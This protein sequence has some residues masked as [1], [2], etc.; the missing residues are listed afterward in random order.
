M[1]QNVN[2]FKSEKSNVQ[3]M[4]QCVCNKYIYNPF[5]I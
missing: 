1:P 5:L 3:S 2:P 4:F